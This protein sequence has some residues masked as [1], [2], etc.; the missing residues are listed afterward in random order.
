MEN[1]NIPECTLIVNNRSLFFMRIHHVNKK[2]EGFKAGL[3]RHL[4]VLCY[5]ILI[6]FIFYVNGC[7]P[8]GNKLTDHF[9]HY[10]LNNPETFQMPTSLNEVSG[11]C[12]LPGSGDSIYSIQDE[13]GKVFHFKPGNPV[14]QV[15]TFR[16]KG[17]YEDIAICKQTIFILR[18][19]GSLFSFPFSERNNPIVTSV[20]NWNAL[21]PK[22]EYEGMF[23]DESSG[24]L[25]ILC[26]DCKKA[27]QSLA[28]GFI[29]SISK[30]ID[31]IQS[32]EFALSSKD[33]EDN[34]ASK[35]NHFRP[36]AFALN[37]GSNEWYILSSVNKMLIVA[38]KEMKVRHVYLLDSSV[39][40]QP[41]GIAFDSS[42]NLYISN[43]ATANHKANI[44][45]FNYN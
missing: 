6:G 15:S 12:F 28:V 42:H 20:K 31:L 25:Y 37:Y 39:F 11:I 36:S 4:F 8:K 32:G 19:D 7:M 17:D 21:L 45:K 35:L 44:L 10:E 5:F 14:L 26:K 27:K 40:Q 30:D 2:K 22:G 33:F 38:D 9:S 29:F 3:E 41:E 34:A 23:A 18:S 24:K 43:E 1:S 16:D 13:K